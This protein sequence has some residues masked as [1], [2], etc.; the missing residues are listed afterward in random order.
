MCT[1]QSLFSRIPQVSKILD[2]P[3]IRE[4]DIPHSIKKDEIILIDYKTSQKAQKNEKY[5]YEF[6][7][8]FYYLWA[9]EKYPDKKIKTIIWQ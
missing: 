7:T 3:N 1:R 8:T 6:Q 9:K 4:I 2:H 5:P